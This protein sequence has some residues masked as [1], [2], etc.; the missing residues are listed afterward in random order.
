[1]LDSQKD[2]NGSGNCYYLDQGCQSHRRKP[3]TEKSSKKKK[4]ITAWLSCRS[5]GEGGLILV[6]KSRKK[7]KKKLPQSPNL[8]RIIQAFR[9]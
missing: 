4:I 7:E 8:R 1:M 2:F 9:I 6:F 3:H 5:N